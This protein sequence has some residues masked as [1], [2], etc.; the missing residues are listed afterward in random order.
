MGLLG[1][2][3]GNMGRRNTLGKTSELLDEDFYWSIIAESLQK[4]DNPNDQER[5]L[6]HRIQKLTPKEIIGFRLR[7]DKLLNECYTP[8][9]W[10]AG[11]IM[12]DGCSDD[13]FEF[14][15]NWVISRGK[16]VYY[17]AKGNPDTLVSEIDEELEGYDFEG[18]WYVADKA[19]KYRTGKE[20]EEFIDDG[21]DQTGGASVEME[22]TWEEGNP[23]SMRQICPELFAQFW[24]E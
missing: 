5:Y 1:K 23:D 18:F 2:V 13:G 14:F 7:T 22:L 21:N 8:A 12:N 10:C 17:R 9:M 4:T 20:L 3:F 11:Y 19:F 15:R 24:N 16:E 6:I